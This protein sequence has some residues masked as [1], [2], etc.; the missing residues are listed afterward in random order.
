MSFS[1]G[2]AL[3][4]IASPLS[5][6]RSVEERIGILGFTLALVFAMSQ[7]LWAHEFKVADIEIVHP[8]SRE[9]PAGAK[10]A[11]GY[12][13]VRNNGTEDDRLVSVSGEIA[14]RTEIHEMAVDDKGV[15]TMRPLGEGIEIPAGG[16]VEL[17]PRSYHVM[18]MDLR[19]APKQGESFAGT[20]TFEKAGTVDIEFSVDAMGGASTHMDHDDHGG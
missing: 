18:F 3:R 1:T 7:S 12:L 19:Q 13:L 2:G 4:A 11:A 5:R 9:T 8:W 20:L 15:M 10:V 16:E 6:F 14:N 17:K